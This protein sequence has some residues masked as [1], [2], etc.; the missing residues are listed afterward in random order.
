MSRNEVHVEIIVA[1]N[2][3]NAGSFSI[4]RCNILSIFRNDQH[5]DIKLNLWS[6]ILVEKLEVA[7]LV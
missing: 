4:R 1:I 7:Q 5:R 6:R 3:E 2:S